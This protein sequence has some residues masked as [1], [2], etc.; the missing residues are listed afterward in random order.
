[1]QFECRVIGHE[2][3]HKKEEIRVKVKLEGT[4]SG[5]KATLLVPEEDRVKY[6][7]GSSAVVDF[8]VQQSIPF[9]KK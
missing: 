4:L 8:S 3:V 6:P 1:M 9:A 7:L 2:L 5:L